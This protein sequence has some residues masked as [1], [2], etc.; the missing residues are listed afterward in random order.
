VG[1]VG[2]G[3]DPSRRRCC[4]HGARVAVGLAAS[5]PE[6]CV[7]RVWRARRAHAAGR[8]GADA[9]TR[10]CG[11]V[12]TRAV[13]PTVAAAAYWVHPPRP[14]RVAQVGTGHLRGRAPPRVPPAACPS[15]RRGRARRRGECVVSLSS[16]SF[17]YCSFAS[18]VLK[19]ETTR[20]PNLAPRPRPRASDAATPRFPRRH[21]K[22]GPQQSP[23]AS[24][25]RGIPSPPPTRTGAR[26]LPAQAPAW[27]APRTRGRAAKRPPCSY[28]PA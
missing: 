2:V 18:Y 4:G 23:A 5:P 12:A 14:V 28:S 7:R 19:K 15:C 20:S 10:A 24:P 9:D 11:S 17:S 21:G 25:T 27:A 26:T 16:N 1:W 3:C 6:R 13:W 22:R 8:R